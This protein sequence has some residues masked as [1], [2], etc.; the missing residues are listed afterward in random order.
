MDEPEIKE[1]LSVISA[2]VNYVINELNHIKY[3]PFNNHE[4]LKQVDE[5]INSV[6]VFLSELRK[7][8]SLV[9]K[10]DWF[11]EFILSA[12]VFGDNGKSINRSILLPII[13]LRNLSHYDINDLPGAGNL[14]DRL[15]MDRI[16]FEVLERKGVDKIEISRDI[17]LSKSL[18]KDN[19]LDNNSAVRFLDDL[20][21]HFESSSFIDL[22]E[23]DG[24]RYFNKEN[25][26]YYIDWQLTF[27]GIEA[28]K[29]INMKRSKSHNKRSD[30]KSIT[31]KLR[32]LYDFYSELKVA[33]YEAGYKFD[34][35]KELLAE[36]SKS[37]ETG[38]NKRAV[39]KLPVINKIKSRID[40]IKKKSVTKK[41][42]KITKKAEV[43]KIADTKKKAKITKKVEAKKISATK[44]KA[45]I[46]KKADLKKASVIK[47]TADKIKKAAI[48]K[49]KK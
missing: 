6:R 29:E 30:A 44:K 24:V 9:N 22:H 4:I 20:A 25:F 47:K 33:S 10:P 12:T 45:K 41:K 48:K 16:F 36:K 49:K 43:K 37:L 17:L 40:D 35:T 15:M 1:I 21:L 7:I 39:R 28:L 3:V 38:K 23:Y 31:N 27:S 8:D 2:D 34:N 46:S 42:A 5:D 14:I 26:D 11:D 18:I 32:S 19:N 13:L